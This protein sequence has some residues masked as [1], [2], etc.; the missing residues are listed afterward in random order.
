MLKKLIILGLILQVVIPVTL[1]SQT[2]SAFSGD[3]TKFRSELTA[4]MGPNLNDEQKTTINKFLIRWDSAAF[5]S[6]IMDKIINVSSQLSSR[7]MR[8][9]P[10]YYDFIV[11]LNTFIDYKR[12]NEFFTNWLK[13][14]SE[15]AFS[16]H[17]T[18]ENIDAYFRNS[19]LMV[20]ENELYESGSVKWK[21]KNNE[22]TFLH[23][24]AIYISVKDATL[25]C[26]VQKDSTELYNV[27]GRYYPDIQ[28]F[29]GSK[30]IVSWG[31]AGYPRKDVFAEISNFS[32]NMK[33]SSFTVDS[34]KLT[35]TAYFKEPVNGLLADQV[36]S[37]SNKDKANYPRFETYAKQFKI[38]NIYKGVNYEGGLKFEGSTM[39][40]NGKNSD[41][42][43][44]TLFR[45]DTL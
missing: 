19:S 4:F 33:K 11:A 13:G 18:N 32:L 28:I 3:R 42:A 44:I 7:Q 22:L 43:K 24:T 41:L 17:F 21:V 30:G 45:N 9:I 40:G 38:K 15:I 14:L 29:I 23:D 31:K 12:D 1:F 5:N 34:A 8:T 10:H 16:Q 35:H 2:K 25:T 6:E 39:K 27:T 26:Y 36:V 37:I 20:K